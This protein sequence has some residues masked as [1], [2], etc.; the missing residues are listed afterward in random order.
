MNKVIL[1]LIIILFSSQSWATN[2]SDPGLITGIFSGKGNIVGFFHSAAVYN[3]AECASAASDQAYLIAYNSTEDWDKVYSMLLA[4]YLS[5]KKIKIGVHPTN[6]YL[7]YPVI[8]R[9]AFERGY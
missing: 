9:V 6:C 5:K 1:T 2:Y 7:D 4:A 8:E 3:P